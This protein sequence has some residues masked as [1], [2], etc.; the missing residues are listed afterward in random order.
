MFYC[1]RRYAVHDNELKNK[2]TFSRF[3][4][5]KICTISPCLLQILLSKCSTVFYLLI[6]S[7]KSSAWTTRIAY[8]SSNPFWSTHCMRQLE[9][10][11]RDKSNQ[12]QLEKE[13]WT[14]S[15]QIIIWYPWGLWEKRF[16]KKKVTQEI[17]EQQFDKLTLLDLL[18]LEL[19]KHSQYLSK[20]EE[21]SYLNL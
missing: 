9:Q 7:F 4:F 17:N 10:H 2:T 1:R 14:V 15:A 11:T 5:H 3:R 18:L 6:Y 21:R 13:I 20:L 16:K 12:T 19:H 8:V